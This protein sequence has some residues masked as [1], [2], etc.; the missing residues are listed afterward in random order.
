MER[1]KEF[2][3]DARHFQIGYLALFLFYGVL[4]LKWEITSIKMLIILGTSLL[5][6][7]LW[8]KITK[9][10]MSGLK[11]ALITGLG[12][13]LILHSDS[14][15][16][17]SIAAVLSISSKFVIRYKNKHLFNPN[18]FGMIIA[19]LVFQDAWISPGQ[20]GSSAL[21][22][23]AI[24]ILGGL[25]LF[26]IGRLETTIVFLGGLFFMEYLRTVVYQGWEMDVLFHKFSSGTLLLFAFFMI[27]DPMT[28]P[29]ARKSRIFWA[30]ILAIATFILSNWMQIYT[31]PIWVL[32]FITPL[33]VFL[34]K[35]YPAVKFEWT[36]TITTK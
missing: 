23:F 10:K 27:T 22:L 15:L 13:C 26:K 19:I 21:F 18:N 17:L 4:E 7:F 28:I 24:S 32:F 30:A 6:Q 16:T 34:D 3:K 2:T 25:I 1:L 35:I 12:I 31:A 14:I 9:G 36:K 33:T 11:S 20:W 5:T 29:N 8:L